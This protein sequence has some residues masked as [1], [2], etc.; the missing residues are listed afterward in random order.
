LSDAAPQSDADYQRVCWQCG[1]T[2]DGDRDTCPEDG[3]QLVE[4]DPS[5]TQDILIGRVYDY[6]YRIVGKLGEGGMSDVYSAKP[7]DDDRDVALKI[8]KADFLRDEEVRKRF[9]YEARTI[10]NLE[11]AHVVDLFDFGQSPDGSFYMVMEL[12]EGQSL[13]SCL[14]DGHLD[15]GEILDIASPIC[16]VLAEAHDRGVIHRDLKP[17]NIYLTDDGEGEWLA[18]L[19]DFGIAKHLRHQTVTK[20]GALWGTPAYMS[21]EQAAGESVTEAVDQYAMGVILFEM[22]TGVLPFRATTAMGYAVKHMNQTAPHMTEVPGLKSVPTRLADLVA[23]MLQKDPSLRPPS[24]QAVT[25]EL[26]AIRQELDDPGLLDFVPATEVRRSAISPAEDPELGDDRNDRDFRDHEGSLVDRQRGNS[27]DTLEGEP[28]EMLG[29]NDERPVRPTR[30]TRP[31]DWGNLEARPWWR[32][33]STWFVAMTTVTVIVAAVL[34]RPWSLLDSDAAG[35]APT[36]ESIEEWGAP[37]EVRSPW[38]FMAPKADIEEALNE[39]QTEAMSRAAGRG[40]WISNRAR[41][42]AAGAEGEMGVGELQ[43]GGDGGDD[44]GASRPA[45][46]GPANIFEQDDSVRKAVEQTF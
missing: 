14:A 42:I 2:Y 38:D 32:E 40:V 33:P 18:K 5:E 20:S 41:S 27:D 1:A 15:Y 9:M 21:P 37:S 31:E 26:D 6:K 29:S 8:L 17:E 36:A 30:Q 43:A 45:G 23:A 11:H 44:A 46:D 7:V 10:S 28:P 13:S 3:A 19:L 35:P 22:V 39:A 24:M 34:Y 12:L 25:E 4:L 16:S